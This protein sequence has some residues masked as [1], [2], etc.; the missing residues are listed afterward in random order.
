MIEHDKIL[1]ALRLVLGWIDVIN[2]NLP[3]RDPYPRRDPLLEAD[4]AVRRAISAIHNSRKFV[5]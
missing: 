4:R 3:R 1:D 5:S 2:K